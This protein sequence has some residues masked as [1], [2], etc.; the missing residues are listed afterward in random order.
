[1]VKI[2]DYFINICYYNDNNVFNVGLKC[3]MGRE[4]LTVDG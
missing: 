1:M 3:S 2:G 4:W